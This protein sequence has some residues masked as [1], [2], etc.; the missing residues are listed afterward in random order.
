MMVALLFVVSLGATRPAVAQQVDATRPVVFTLD[1]GVSLPLSGR[2]FGGFVT[3]PLILGFLGVDLHV[4]VSTYV[5]LG[6]FGELTPA[7][8]AVGGGSA[9]FTQ[10]WRGQPARVTAGLGP[11]YASSGAALAVGD[12]SLEVRSHI[13]VALLFGPAVQVVLNQIG[14]DRCGVDTCDAYVPPGSYLV[15]VRLGLGFSL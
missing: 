2:F 14:N 5:G 13:G 4:D 9:R 3:S 10:P 12:V 15:L 8:G 11:A 6:F 7:L 1:A